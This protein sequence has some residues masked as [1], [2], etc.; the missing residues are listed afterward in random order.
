MTL[1][2]IEEFYREH[3]DALKLVLEQSGDLCNTRYYLGHEEAELEAFDEMEV[4]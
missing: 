4:E 1:K 3:P 2:E